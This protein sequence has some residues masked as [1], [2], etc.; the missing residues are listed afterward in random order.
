MKEIKVGDMVKVIKSPYSSVSKGDVSRVA[1]IRT[2]GRTLPLY[3]LSDLPN[4]NFYLF[5][6]ELI[7]EVK[8]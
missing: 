1:E 7:T 6:I 3:T 5:E 4:K 8:K 2:D